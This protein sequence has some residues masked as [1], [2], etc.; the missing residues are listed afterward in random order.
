MATATYAFFYQLNRQGGNFSLGATPTDVTGA[1]SSSV[2]EPAT[3]PG[4]FNDGESVTVSDAG[5]ANG[6][7]FYRGTV[8]FS[9]TTY[10]V[11]GTGSRGNGGTFYVGSNVELSSTGNSSL[12]STNTSPV[13]FLAGTL[14]AT[15]EGERAIEELVV[16]DLVTTPS[17]PQPVKFVA[18][19]TRSLNALRA[20]GRM[21]IHI[22]AGALGAHGP[23]R[24]TFLTAS[25]AVLLED[26]LV[27]AGALVNGKTIVQMNDHDSLFLTYYNIELE[28]HALIR[29]NGLQAETYYANF[30]ADGLSR[31][32]WDNYAEYVALYGADSSMQELPMPRIPFA[33][34]LPA[35][36][37]LTLQ[38]AEPQ[39]AVV[40]S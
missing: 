30:R 19:S 22:P 10:P 13:C 32:S 18:R 40:A 3:S 26:Q 27:E 34:Q 11:F 12:T 31:Q 5:A 14:I 21:P 24:D 20:T 6:T 35:A 1:G 17:G 16:G 15:P 23:S 9:G 28:A 38:L 25:H 4:T 8:T 37:R 2:T 33:R 36:L 29:A 39:A 7:L